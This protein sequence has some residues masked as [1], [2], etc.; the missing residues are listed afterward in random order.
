MNWLYGLLLATG[1]GVLL[2]LAVGLLLFNLK[3]RQIIHAAAIAS[4]EQLELIYRLFERCGSERPR[5]CVLARTNRHAAGKACVLS[6]PVWLTDF[7]WAGR[8]I[9]VDAGSEVTFRFTFEPVAEP[10]F[11]GKVFQAVGVPRIRSKSGKARH[12]LAPARCVSSSEALRNALEAVCPRYPVDLLSYLLCSGAET[13]EFDGIN[14]ALI[15]SRPAWVQDREFQFCDK[16]K[17]RMT[18]ILQLPGTMIEPR[19]LSRGTFYLFGCRQ[20]PDCTKSVNQFT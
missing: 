8:T 15:G 13:F 11:L 10:Q 18:L 1:A 19:S 9:A 14:Q 7:P 20:H 6:I 4:E 3:R 2:A 5:G 12:R 16:C 17:Q